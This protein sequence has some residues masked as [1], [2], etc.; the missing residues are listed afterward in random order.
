MDRMAY[1]VVF[2]YL[3]SLFHAAHSVEDEVKQSLIKFLS[4]LSQGNGQID[5]SFGWNMSSD[6]CNGQWKGVTCND[7]ST[8]VKKINLDNLN[9]IGTL[10][11]ESLCSVQSL[12][13]LSLNNNSITGEISEEIGKCKQL[14]HFY[15]HSNRLLGRLPNSFSGLSNLKRLVISNNNFSGELPNMPRI[16]GLITFLAENNQFTEEIP[17]FDFSNLQQFNVSFD[18][19]S[20]PVPDL[21]GRFGVDSIMGNP[22]L[23]GNPLFISCPPSPSPTKKSSGISTEKFLTYSGYIVIGLIFL[24]FVA[25][26]LVKRKNRQGKTSVVKKGVSVDGTSSKPSKV[27]SSENKSG[28]SRSEYSITSVESG[29]LSTPLVILTSPV[30]KELTFEDLLKAPAELIGRGRHGSLYKVTMEDGTTLSVKRI[31]DWNISSDEF[32]QRMEK[33]DKVKHPNVSPAVAF[34]CSK[35]EKLLVYEYQQNGSLY[36]LLHGSQSGETFDWCSRLNIAA[37]VADALAFMHENHL[38]DGIPHGNLKSSNILFDKHMDL[39][40]SEY[41]LMVVDSQD[42]LFLAH[43]GG[44]KTVDNSKDAHNSFKIDIYGFG[45]ILL[46]LLTGKLVQSNGS[47]LARWVHSVVREEWTVEVFDKELI[48]EGASEE[49]MVNLLQVALK[50]INPSPEARPSMNQVALIINTIKEEEERSIVSET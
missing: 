8:S 12:A 4:K 20:G 18:N 5:P 32:K 15:A 49:R 43:G 10:D 41:G 22:G 28:V 1:W 40:I 33:V 16:S 24:S 6:P 19:F 9:L 45:V 7:Q 25:F 14:T 39:C 35:E 27:T 46:E 29:M 34:Y 38:D 50:C 37:S 26:K 17:D 42:S 48:L 31:K 21:K 11:A 36:R 2:I 30:A 44:N 23:C 13:V 47:E 3:F